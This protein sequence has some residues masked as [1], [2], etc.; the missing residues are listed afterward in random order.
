MGEVGKESKIVLTATNPMRRLTACVIFTACASNTARPIATVLPAAPRSSAPTATTSVPTPPRSASPPRDGKVY[1]LHEGDSALEL[2]KGVTVVR[3][4]GADPMYTWRGN[5]KFAN[6]G[7]S[8]WT[9]MHAFLPGDAF[10]ISS[11]W[12]GSRSSGGGSLEIREHD[13]SPRDATTRDVQIRVGD[14]VTVG[15]FTLVWGAVERPWWDQKRSLA[16][17]LRADN[18]DHERG[19]SRELLGPNDPTTWWVRPD[20]TTSSARVR[21]FSTPEELQH[22]E[23]T[24]RELNRGKEPLEHE[25]TVRGRVVDR[26]QE[27]KLGAPLGLGF[28]KFADGLR[29]RVRVIAFCRV[30]GCN[31]REC[32]ASVGQDAELFS[33]GKPGTT[34][35]RFG[36]TFHFQTDSVVV[37]K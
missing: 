25:M 19:L 21:D 28:Y 33:F 5:E 30:G 22:I 26:A 35:Q 8:A 6:G 15:T 16:F 27:A 9:I 11:R 12:V 24:I 1:T 13:P 37:T 17:V 4:P 32:T 36:H 31:Q 7:S 34:E 23:L 3:E 18:D 14:R 2:T 20:E 29:F 10:L